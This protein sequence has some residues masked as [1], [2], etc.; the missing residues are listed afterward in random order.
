VS[1]D[2]SIK[3]PAYFV[4]FVA[5]LALTGLTVGLARVNLGAWHTPVGLAIATTKA[6]LILLIFM[7]VLHGS[8]ITWLLAGTTL[9]FLAI[10]ILLTITDYLSRDWQTRANPP[11][12]MHGTFAS[13][14]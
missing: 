4:V 11:H 7:H 14:D 13:R 10:L 2:N 1:S 3:P 9:L 8:K 5:L 6:V 12:G